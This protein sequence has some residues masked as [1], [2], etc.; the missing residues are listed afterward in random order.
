MP[1][2]VLRSTS[3]WSPVR[4]TNTVKA[5]HGFSEEVPNLSER[6][7]GTKPPNPSGGGTLQTFL[8]MVW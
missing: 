1:R 6:P 3:E 5:R 2:V 4:M 7:W 8:S